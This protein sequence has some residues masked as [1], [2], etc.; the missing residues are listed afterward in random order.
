MVYGGA[1]VYNCQLEELPLDE[2]FVHTLRGSS[3]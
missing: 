1:E 2:I 3:V